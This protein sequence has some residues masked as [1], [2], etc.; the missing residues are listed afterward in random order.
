MKKFELKNVT[1]ELETKVSKNGNEYSACV[2][3]CDNK[4]YH[5]GFDKE[6]FILRKIFNGGKE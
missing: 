1:I 5:I 3:K 4:L 2:L 6:Y